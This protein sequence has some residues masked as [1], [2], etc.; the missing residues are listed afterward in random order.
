MV[1]KKK[2]HQ[3][4]PSNKLLNHYI[5]KEVAVDFKTIV[6]KFETFSS[7]RS[8]VRISGPFSPTAMV[9]S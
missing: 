1:S 2:G 8:A 6:V 5:L 9:F 7:Y 4:Q 3:N